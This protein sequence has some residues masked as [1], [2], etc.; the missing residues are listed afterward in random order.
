LCVKSINLFSELNV[1]NIKIERFGEG[2]GG[3]GGRQTVRE[4]RE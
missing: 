3:E 2:R 1:L 4:R